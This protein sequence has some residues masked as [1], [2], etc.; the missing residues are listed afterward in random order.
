MRL[1]HP[2]PELVPAFHSHLLPFHVLLKV[3]GADPA[4][5]ELCEEGEERGN[6]L[7]VGGGGGLGVGGAEGVQEGPG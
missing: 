4:W 3:F 7:L 5:V 1:A 6:V 2:L